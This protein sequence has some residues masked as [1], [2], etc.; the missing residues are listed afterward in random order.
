MTAPVRQIRLADASEAQVTVSI[1]REAAAWQK[2]NG[3]PHWQT[4]SLRLEIAEL[5]IRSGELFLGFEN[6]VACACTLIQSS[7]LIFW[8]EKPAGSAHYL[9]R[10][11]VRRSHARRGW[12]AA[13]IE[14][15]AERAAKNKLPLRLDCFPHPKLMNFYHAQ[16]FLPVDDGPV[17]RGG[18]SVMRYERPQSLLL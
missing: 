3:L 9:H 13:L 1:W 11:A 14:W 8:P 2:E 15:A 18:F 16:G 4:E 17:Q 10:F 7:D 6:N 5:K 12:G